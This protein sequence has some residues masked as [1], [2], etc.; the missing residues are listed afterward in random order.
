MQN[1]LTNIQSNL[2]ESILFILLRDMNASLLDV[3]IE[4][5]REKLCLEYSKLIGTWKK[6]VKLKEFAI[7]NAKIVIDKWVKFTG[8]TLKLKRGT[9][10]LDYP[11]DL[12]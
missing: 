2:F 5:I 9:L 1:P 12:T 4:L 10:N 8:F 6:K 7:E 11:N 3:E